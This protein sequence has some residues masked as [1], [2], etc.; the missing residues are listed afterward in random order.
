MSH[1]RFLPADISTD[2]TT[3]C[4]SRDSPPGVRIVPRNFVAIVLIQRMP[5]PSVSF[6]GIWSDSGQ[7]IAP[8]PGNGDSR[9]AAIQMM[10]FI[11]G[12]SLIQR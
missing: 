4:A 2:G 6:R 3:A 11:S 10:R 5:C 9:V 12:Y 1:L 7:G 8:S